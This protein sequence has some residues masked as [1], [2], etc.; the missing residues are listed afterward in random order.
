MDRIDD[1]T[2]QAVLA[3]LT[4][5]LGGGWVRERRKARRD[6]LEQ[7]LAFIDL[8]TARID[9]LERQVEDLQHQLL[10][11][12]YAPPPPPPPPPP[13]AATTAEG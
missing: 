1:T 4:A 3:A 11:G 13:A 7:A 9:K 2:L 10:G 8:Q 12:G 5:V 6:A